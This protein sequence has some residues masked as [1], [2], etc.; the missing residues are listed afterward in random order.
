MN[1]QIVLLI[2][3]VVLLNSCAPNATPNVTATS[4]ETATSTFTPAPTSTLAITTT[5]TDTP[6]PNMPVDATEKDAATDLYTKTAEDGKTTLY[7]EPIQYGTDV[8]NNVTGHWVDLL[9]EN[10][11]KIFLFNNALNST[12]N[13][14]HDSIPFQLFILDQHQQLKVPFAIRNPDQ[15]SEF[16]PGTPLFLQS[17]SSEIFEGIKLRYFN[18]TDPSTITPAQYQDF[19]QNMQQDALTLS[20]E[21]Q[22]WLISKGYTEIVVD[23]TQASQ[24]LTFRKTDNYYWK[25]MVVDQK[26]ICLIATPEPDKLSDQDIRIMIFAP[27]WEVLLHQKL[28]NQIA[29]FYGGPNGQVPGAEYAI[30]GG[31]GVI[32]KNVQVQ[33]KTDFIEMDY[34]Q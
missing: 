11:Q 22:K 13:Y 27:L 15:M 33:P 18:T 30:L 25:I 20:I 4:V 6:D 1:K 5:P 23:Y 34:P 32:Y 19:Y 2:M 12:N 10:G 14:L 26:L 17:L 9:N 21:G 7:W 8:A 16:G 3:F 24:D 28:P 31:T 29:S